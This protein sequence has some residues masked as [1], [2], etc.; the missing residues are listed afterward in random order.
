MKGI[1][2]FAMSGLSQAVLVAMGFMLASLLFPPLGILSGAVIALVALRQGWYPATIVV[3]ILTAVL[4]ALAGAA[5]QPT[6]LG[7]LSGII[8]WL[9]VML[10]ALILR[11]TGSWTIT[12]QWLLLAALLAVL[13]IHLAVPD[14]QGYWSGVLEKYVRAMLEQAGMPNLE[15][16]RV[17]PQLAGVMTGVLMVSLVV[18]T[19]LMLMLGR[20]MQASLYNPGGFASE[21][22]ELRLGLWPAVL[23]LVLILLTV[24]LKQAALS[25][26]L[27]IVLGLFFFQG[28]AV[29][30][31]LSR[32]MQWPAGIL[33]ILYVTLIVFFTPVAALLAGI[34][35]VDA[36]ADARHRVA[37]Q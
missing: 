15:I 33:V 21:F 30:H 22:A 9:P 12:M 32:K 7:L 3:A 23:A 20:A 35:L 37:G 24:L 26:A 1:A 16:D 6:S 14:L 4:A 27:V 8:Q 2:R 10:L 29:M 34:G 18:S 17:L 19:V 31:G 13:V 25:E 5:G 36:F 11:N 28:L